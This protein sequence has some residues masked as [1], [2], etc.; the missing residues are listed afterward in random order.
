VFGGDAGAAIGYLDGYQ[1]ARLNDA[2]QH[3]APGG[4][5]V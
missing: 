4:R 3:A 1:V 2:D 5:V